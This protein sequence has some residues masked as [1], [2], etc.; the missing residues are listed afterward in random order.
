MLKITNNQGMELCLKSVSM[1]G[2]QA[3]NILKSKRITSRTKT[4]KA[5]LEY[6]IQKI[7]GNKVYLE[8]VPLW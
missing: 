1:I 7:E 3:E 8:S 2:A 6:K 4:I 5:G